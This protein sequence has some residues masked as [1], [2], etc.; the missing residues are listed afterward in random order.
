MFALDDTIK[1]Y[2]AFL[3]RGKGF[4]DNGYTLVF[5]HQSET[6]WYFK[7]RHPNGNI[8]DLKLYPKELRLVQLTNGIECHSDTMR[9]P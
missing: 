2:A 8:I 9:Q 4:I 7:Y 6:L 1:A 3:H 5:Q